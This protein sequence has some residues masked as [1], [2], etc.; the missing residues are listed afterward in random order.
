MRMPSSL[1]TGSGQAW[2]TLVKQA[3]HAYHDDPGLLALTRLAAWRL[4]LTAQ[5]RPPGASLPDAVRAV[6]TDGLQR[7]QASDALGAAVLRRHYVEREPMAQLALDLHFSER[8]LFKHQQAGL[9]ALSQLLWQAEEHAQRVAR[10]SARQQQALDELP[11]PTFSRLFG[12]DEI[13]SA[14][15]RFLTDAQ[16]HWLVALDGMGG[17]GKTALARAACEALIYDGRFERV[18]WITVQQRLFAWGRAHNLDA[19][20]L[21]YAQLLDELARRLDL[22]ATTGQSADRR[23]A[24]VRA[25]LGEH[26]TLVVVDNLETAP[27]VQSLV[28]GLHRL[29]HPARIL[30]TSRYAVGAFDPVTSLTTRP[31]TLHDAVN[32]IR[33]EGQDR[34][35]EALHH[36]SEEDLLRVARITDGNPLAIK[37]VVGQLQSLP[38][39]QVLADLVQV[40]EGDHDLYRYLFAYA[41]QHLSRPARHLLLHMPLL[42]ARGTA[43]QHLA[44]VSGVPADDEFCRAIQ[45]LVNA[46]LLNVGHAVQDTVYSIHRLTEYFV[47]SELV[48]VMTP[49][50]RS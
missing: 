15:R 29:S 26:P 10:L 3:L 12:A 50:A 4:V 9:A 13:L 42:D 5:Q 38:L 47:L 44:A 16:A 2:L 1:E 32:F 40:S 41:W 46:S 31:L 14:L 49:A 33:Y 28:M 20:A 7:L 17:I 19:P 11:T 8:S 18:I 37:W 35:I 43:W 6:L 36:A 23:E 27:D 25:A 22:A 21:S 24:P 34:N 39:G 30:L 45:E 48:G